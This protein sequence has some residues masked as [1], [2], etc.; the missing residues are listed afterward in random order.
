[1]RMKNRRKCLIVL[2]EVHQAIGG[3][4][5]FKENLTSS[6]IPL[7]T[8]TL[9]IWRKYWRLNWQLRCFLSSLHMRNR[10]ICFKEIWKHHSGDLKVIRIVLH[11]S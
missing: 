3:I 5:T 7:P 4:S 1:M 2:P 11:I 6:N 9:S 8:K 10:K